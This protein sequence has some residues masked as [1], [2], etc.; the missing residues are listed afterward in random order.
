MGGRVGKGG[1]VGVGGRVGNG[2]VGVGTGTVG[3]GG[4][5][6]ATGRVG[7]GDGVGIG[8]NVGTGGNVGVGGKVRGV[9]VAGICVADELGS[10]GVCDAGAVCFG[11][12]V[13]E[14]LVGCGVPLDVLPELPGFGVCVG[15]PADGALVGFGVGSDG[16]RLTSA[17]GAGLSSEAISRSFRASWL[18][19]VSRGGSTKT[20]S[21]GP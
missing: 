20:C 18:I 11:V 13:G 15:A 8:G 10:L 16:G 6:V 19:D 1:S 9:A 17:P 2:G 12:G 21:S 14:P 4:V 7:T 3:S 5:G